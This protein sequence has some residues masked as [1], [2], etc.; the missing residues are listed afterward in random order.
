MGAMTEPADMCAEPRRGR[1]RSAE[2]DI[3]ILAAALELA[4]EV[5]VRAMSM[6]E[7][8]ARAGVSKATIY[9]RWS[10]K[11]AMILDALRSAIEPVGAVDHGSLG[12]DLRHYLSDMTARMTVSRGDV[13]PHL[14]EVA[15]Y[16]P[17]IRTSL[18]DW[19]RH[20]RAPL[21]AILE[22]GVERG[23]LPVDTDL[24]LLLDALIGPFVYRRL[25]TGGAIDESV[26]DRLLALV[27]PTV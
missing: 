13:L 16:D 2:A 25:L 27:L 6:D 8:A 11:E 4:I 12:A 9:R 19:V 5:G 18:D 21:L 1:P 15:C 14:I 20:R 3:A 7:V 17:A 22:R 24:E 26:V 23:E 10:S